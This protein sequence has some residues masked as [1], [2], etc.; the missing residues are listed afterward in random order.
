MPP[1]AS[2][3][4]SDYN[5]PNQRWHGKREFKQERGD[6]EHRQFK[7]PKRGPRKDRHMGDR[8]DEDGY[9]TTSGE[10][11]IIASESNERPIAKKEENGFRIKGE[12][13]ESAANTTKRGDSPSSCSVSK[14]EPSCESKSSQQTSQQSQPPILQIHVIDLKTLFYSS[15]GSHT[16]AD[17]VQG[18]AREL[19]LGGGGIPLYGML[20]KGEYGSG[21]DAEYVLIDF[22]A[23]QSDGPF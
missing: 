10:E 13:R 3:R 16:G 17:S 7:R 22:L 11:D 8:F 15:T 9:D 1:R 19:N 21:W 18:M 14:Q 2:E 23:Y 5:N 6:D 12:P 20:G 4:H